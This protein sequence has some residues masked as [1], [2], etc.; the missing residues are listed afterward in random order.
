MWIETKITDLGWCN[1]ITER[2]GRHSAPMLADLKITVL[3]N[4]APR[5][6]Y[7]QP[8]PGINGFR[9]M[10]TWRPGNHWRLMQRVV[11]I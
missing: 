1:K 9:S 7:Q 10:T 8:G 11:E 6:A 2:A 3:L 4:L 5:L